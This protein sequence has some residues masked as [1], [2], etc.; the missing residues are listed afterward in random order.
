MRANQAAVQDTTCQVPAVGQDPPIPLNA[1]YAAMMTARQ[2][3]TSVNTVP[4]KQ[5]EISLAA[6]NAKP[7]AQLANIWTKSALARHI[8]MTMNA[9]QQCATPV[10]S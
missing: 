9:S 8:P 2:A 6:P 3:P 1:R 4:A 7:A 10:S 5:P